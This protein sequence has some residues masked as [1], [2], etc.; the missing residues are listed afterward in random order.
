M[1]ENEE[2]LEPKYTVG[3]H[4]K[5]YDYSG[6]KLF[7]EGRG[8]PRQVERESCRGAGSVGVEPTWGFPL[9]GKGTTTRT[10]ES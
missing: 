8:R 5:L 7:R 1:G 2:R 4:V 10:G 3:G 9:W 6:K